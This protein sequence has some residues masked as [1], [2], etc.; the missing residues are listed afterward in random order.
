MEADNK[1]VVRRVFEE[2]FNQRRFDLIPTLYCGDCEGMDPANPSGVCGHEALTD[3]L[4][5]H[6]KTFP[7]HRYTVHQI[8]AEA[9]YVSVRWSVTGLGRKVA[10]G[11]TFEGLSLC[12]F[13]DKKICRVWQHWDN[14]GLMQAMGVVTPELQ[15]ADELQNLGGSPD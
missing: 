15:V 6:C 4:T 3:L 7:D 1:S 13:R 12:E 2:I 9:E 14:L 11:A 10:Q 8:I 5:L